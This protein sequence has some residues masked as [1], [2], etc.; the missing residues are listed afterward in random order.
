[1]QKSAHFTILF[2]WFIS[3]SM[4]ETW[5]LKLCRRFCHEAL[6]SEQAFCVTLVIKRAASNQ[7]SCHVR[8]GMAQEA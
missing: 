6:F 2:L 7:K 4:F 5:L 8:P 1:M 3:S